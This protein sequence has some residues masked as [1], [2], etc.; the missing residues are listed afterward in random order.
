MTTTIW[1][2]AWVQADID[3]AS[4]AAGDYSTIACRRVVI[5]ECRELSQTEAA[6]AVGPLGRRSRG[7]PYAKWQLRSEHYMAPTPS[8][9]SIQSARP[10][11][12]CEVLV[13]TDEER[14]GVVKAIGGSMF[15]PSAPLRWRMPGDVRLD[16][17][18]H[19]ASD[20]I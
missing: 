10:A 19:D 13:P 8:G 1:R 3:F 18:V 4:D 14:A 6:R 20:A 11:G 2:E 12:K 9:R 15:F 5:R 17:E 16:H 7:E